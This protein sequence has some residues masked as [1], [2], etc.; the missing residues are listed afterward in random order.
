MRFNSIFEHMER[1]KELGERSIG[2]IQS[3]NRRINKKCTEPQI[4]ME[5]HK[6]YKTLITGVAE[7]KDIRKNI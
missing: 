7:G 2:I 3:R 6:V 1:I 4:L 5:H